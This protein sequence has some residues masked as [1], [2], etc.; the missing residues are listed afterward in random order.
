MNLRIFPQ[1]L[2]K[3]TIVI[4][5]IYILS[6][7]SNI[8]LPL[9]LSV[10]LAFILS[11]LTEKITNVNIYGNRIKINRSIAILLSFFITIA[12]IIGIIMI[13]CVPLLDEFYKLYR[14]IPR[15]FVAIQSFMLEMEGS[16][17]VPIIKNGIYQEQSE[18]FLSLMQKMITGGLAMFLH[19]IKNVT[20]LS[21]HIMS[22]IVDFVA[23]PVLTFY[24]IRDWR[25]LLQDFLRL[26]DINKREKI[27]RA[28]LEMGKVIR[29]FIYGQFCLC[30]IIGGCM[31][32]G[33]S[34]LHVNYPLLLAMVAA[35]A[36]A[37][38]VVGPILSAI[39]AIILA[40]A[41]STNVALKVAAFCFSLQ[42]LENHI[43]VPKIMGN[44]INLHPTIIIISLLI[45]GQLFG[46]IG[47]LFSLPI[48]AILKVLMQY[49]W[50]TEEKI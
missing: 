13:I 3:Y 19:L 33:L 45:G 22:R 49:F 18:Q 2:F 41:I 14:D 10:L 6:Q 16:I 4:G 44:S 23:I 12:V 36:E 20:N 50:F 25:V 48:T 8:Y 28:L 32:L 17:L 40:F 35:I 42:L 5:G 30:I 38:P 34:I 11:P 47:M 37:I 29:E 43:I 21:M 46:V 27:C 7:S 39:P 1:N 15:I 31:F 24:F 9:S 26:I